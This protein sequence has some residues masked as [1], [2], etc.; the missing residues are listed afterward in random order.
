MLVRLFR[1]NIGNNL[2]ISQSSWQQKWL[3][4]EEKTV[5]MMYSAFSKKQVGQ[6]LYIYPLNTKYSL[7]VTYEK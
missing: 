1:K 6:I 7:S 4:E 2:K 5:K 3:L